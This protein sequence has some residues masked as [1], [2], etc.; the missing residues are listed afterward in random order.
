GPD[1]YHGHGFLNANNAVTTSLAQQ[2]ASR[3]ERTAEAAGASRVELVIARNGGASAPEISFTLPAA[4]LAR[5]ELFD[6]A[7]RRVAEL[8]NGPASAGRTAV[9]WNARSLRQGAYFAR[10]TA[11]GVQSSRQL[12][13]MGP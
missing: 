7:G 3:P 9:A 5:V 11:N 10:L 4:G 8:Y 6:I 13:L 1:P 12:V 2:A